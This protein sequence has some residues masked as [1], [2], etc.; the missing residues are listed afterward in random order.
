MSELQ[1]LTKKERRRLKKLKKEENTRV[2]QR[3]KKI[4]SIIIYGIIFVFVGLA[5]S[6]IIYL[7]AKKSSANNPISLPA[8]L[9]L[10]EDDWLKGN[11][12]AELTLIEYSDFQ[13][14]ACAYFHPIVEKLAEDYEDYKEDLKIVYRHFPLPQ[15]KNA[16]LAGQAAE[17]AGKQGKFWEMAGMIFE[18]QNRWSESEQDEAKNIFRELARTLNLNIEQW[19]KDI[20]NE[21][22]KK[23]IDEDYK[24]GVKIG[25]N[26][27][28]TFFL[29]GKK[30]QNPRS[31]EEF[32]EMLNKEKISD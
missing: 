5:V 30:L 17:A 11:K 12:E 29:N 23:S 4:N 13:C 31:Y 8:S 19:E 24:E 20:E 2:G 27:T 25:I 16:I 14:P 32:K 21:D 1:N 3:K 22:I 9:I 26:A 6:G 7:V 18:S 15:H 10:L 28:P